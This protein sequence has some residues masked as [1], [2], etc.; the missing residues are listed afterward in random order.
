[1]ITCFLE[2]AISSNKS[3][4]DICHEKTLSIIP[5]YAA[6]VKAPPHLTGTI[7]PDISRGF[8]TAVNG[9]NIEYTGTF[10]VYSGKE[11]TTS[12]D[13]GVTAINVKNFS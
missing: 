13:M 5:L 6:P 4:T 10:P 1:M 2:F 11:R 8:L 12:D 9:I 7:R 3:K